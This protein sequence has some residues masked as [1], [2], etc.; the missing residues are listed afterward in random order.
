MQK[1]I[2]I[3]RSHGTSKRGNDY[4]LTEVSNGLASFTLSNDVGVGEALKG[5][6]LGEGEE[7]MAEVHVTPRYGSLAGTIVRVEET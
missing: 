7:F 4:D 3:R 5:M 2:Y 1:L 6:E